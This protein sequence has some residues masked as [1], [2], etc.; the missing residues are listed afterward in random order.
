MAHL[1]KNMRHH[2]FAVAEKTNSMDDVPYNELFL[3][4]A[5]FAWQS[6]RD[7]QIL[8]RKREKEQKAL[9][10]QHRTEKNYY[11]GETTHQKKRLAMLE[12]AVGFYANNIWDARVAVQSIT[13]WASWRRD[14]V[15]SA[16]NKQGKNEANKEATKSEQMLK[17]EQRKALDSKLM[18]MDEIAKVLSRERTRLNQSLMVSGWHRHVARSRSV[19]HV[20]QENQLKLKAQ[21]QADEANQNSERT[22]EEIKLHVAQIREALVEKYADC[23]KTLSVLTAYMLWKRCF[24]VTQIEAKAALELQEVQKHLSA[25]SKARRLA[26]TKAKMATGASGARKGD[27]E[28]NPLGSVK[29]QKLSAGLKRIVNRRLTYGFL[30]LMENEGADEFVPA[31]L[32]EAHN[33]PLWLRCNTH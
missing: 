13:C 32:H 28:S 19:K 21:Q 18:A 4:T 25:E 29:S 15:K 3:H 20:Q 11:V 17:D 16:A 23:N 22:K 6:T 30:A 31:G 14:A 1:R 24:D 27:E 5:L 26:E 8:L 12:N 10:E 33:D 9:E 2:G 7:A